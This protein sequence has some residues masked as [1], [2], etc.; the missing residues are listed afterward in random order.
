MLK[1]T[2]V[3]NASV[4]D[5]KENRVELSLFIEIFYYIWRKALH[6]KLASNHIFTIVGICLLIS[7]VQIPSAFSNGDSGVSLEIAIETALRENPKL[8]AIREKVK[9]A[10]ARVEGIALLDN[11]RLETEF[12]G[13]TGFEQGF[14]L[15]QT[16]QLGGQRGHQRRIATTHLEKV[17]VELAEASRLLTK[18]V[19]L[20]FYELALVQE[21]LRL[22][23]EII[24]HTEQMRDIAQFQFEA[25]DIS[26]TQA[27]LA[28]IQLQSALREAS[29]LAGELHLAQIALNG[30]MGISLETEY[31]AIDGLPEKISANAHEKLTL[32]TLETHA[33]THRTDLK[34][35]QLD[36]QLTE[37]ELQLAK[38]ANIPDLSVGALAQR[39]T[40]ENIFGVKFILP[41]PLF[42]RNRAKINA[43]EAQ[44][45]V[46][47]VRISDIERQIIREVMSA[48][49]S[50]NTAE[51]TIAFY[52]GDSLTLLNENLSLTREAYELGEAELLEVILM[53]NEFIKTRFAYLEALAA[54][55]KA[56]AQ[57]EAAIGTSIEAV[58]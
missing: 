2:I 26:V 12:A 53:Q 52:E 34:S 40:D 27:N 4:F 5:E 29:T 47:T 25:G 19:K 11:P 9:V 3:E 49:L 37:N 58:P 10:R 20:A 18:S 32:A 31:I 41:L 46:D 57:L 13:G 56:L 17:N 54:Y 22:A 33:L 35:F 39:S 21:K 43:A 48:F 28:N 45:Q 1:F 15:T 7:T 8:K 42:D 50:L 55:Y 23:K 38:A 16:F 6:T 51:K 14:E 24:Q 30:L 36:A 44:Q